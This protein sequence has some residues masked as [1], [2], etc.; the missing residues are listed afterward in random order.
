MPVK[1]E[2][3]LSVAEN[4]HKNNPTEIEVRC[5][6]S[7]SY[8]AMYHKALSVL[9]KEPR[10]Y[11]SKGCHG[12]LVEYL[13]QDVGTDEPDK[14]AMKLRQVSYILEQERANRVRADYHLDDVV[15][16]EQAGDSIQAA[17]RCIEL[18]A[19]V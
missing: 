10:T 15:T 16:V 9:D 4:F 11:H 5:I 7:R 17:N 2:E 13:K 8:Y 12:S 6:V 19:K 1:P 18:C 14:D 3:F